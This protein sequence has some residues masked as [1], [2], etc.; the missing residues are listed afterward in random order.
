MNTLI[1]LS[2]AALLWGASSIS[3]ALSADW[4]I[5]KENRS[6]EFQLKVQNNE[7][8]GRFATFDATIKLDPENPSTGSIEVVVDTTTITTGNP[9]GDNLVQSAKWMAIADYNKAVFKSTS[10]SKSGDGYVAE[11]ELVVR[12]TTLPVTLNFNLS[13]DGDKAKAT[14][15]T[16]LD[17]MD[18]GV[19]PE[20]SSSLPVGEAVQIIFEL[21]ASKAN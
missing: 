14:G 2:M 20:P 8:K 6:L 15:K 1:K 7:V 12:E 9:Q 5:D 16:D 13:V 10:I 3:P 18:F 17:R 19:G 4:I 11:G 21:E